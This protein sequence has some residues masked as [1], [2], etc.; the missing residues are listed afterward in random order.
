MLLFYA[1]FSLSSINLTVCHDDTVIKQSLICHLK[2]FSFFFFS[3]S[4]I[5]QVR[6]DMVEDLKNKII[7]EYD[8]IQWITAWVTKKRVF[9][10]LNKRWLCQRQCRCWQEYRYRQAHAKYDHIFWLSRGTDCF[11]IIVV[12]CAHK[13][14]YHPLRSMSV[15]RWRTRRILIW[16]ERVWQSSQIFF[17]N[18]NFSTFFR[19]Y[20][21]LRVC[22]VVCLNIRC[23]WA[24]C[25]SVCFLLLFSPPRWII[26]F[27]FRFLWL[28]LL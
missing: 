6:F 18:F 5:T 4:F 17:L 16:C 28:Y 24:R 1:Y 12:Q 19:F 2:D 22:G 21:L 14:I 10:I 15:P 23:R 11:V 3:L 7:D 25:V 26:A 13:I 20:V 27:R 8:S 9:L